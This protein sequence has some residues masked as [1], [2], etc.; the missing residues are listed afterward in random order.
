MEWLAWLPYIALSGLVVFAMI[1]AVIV[2]WIINVYRTINDD[3]ERYS[4]ER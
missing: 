1:F 4:H 3:S 2:M